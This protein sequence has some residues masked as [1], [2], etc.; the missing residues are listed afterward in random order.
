[1]VVCGLLSRKESAKRSPN[2]GRLLS[3]SGWQ[4][5]PTCSNCNAHKGKYIF[6]GMHVKYCNQNLNIFSVFIYHCGK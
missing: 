2:I 4:C 3:F 1:M 6:V 5:S